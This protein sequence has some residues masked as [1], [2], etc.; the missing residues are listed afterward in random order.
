MSKK[1][2]IALIT[3]AVV[4]LA[5]SILLIILPTNGLASYMF[6]LRGASVSA[7]CFVPTSQS[8]YPNAWQLLKNAGVN[9]IRVSGGMEGDVNHFNM[10][11]YPGEW[12]QNLDDFLTQ[13]ASYGIKVSFTS[14]GNIHG[15][16]FGIVP[17][18]ISDQSDPNAAYTPISQAK[19]MIDQL[20]GNNSLHHNFIMDPRILGW[21]TSN[22]VYIGSQTNSNPNRD[23]P[24]ILKWNLQLLDYIRSKG[25]KAWISSPTVTENVS[26]YDFAKT[27]SLIG[28]HVDFLEAHYYEEPELLTYFKISDGTYNW[29]SFR[30]YYKNLLLNQMV[31]VRGNFSIHGILLGE[32]GMSLGPSSD[33]GF[34]SNFTSQDRI[35]YYQAILVAA[36]DAGLQNVCQH[37]FFEQANT[38]INNYAIVSLSSKNF[39][40]HDA[41]A[42]LME[43]YG[44]VSSSTSKNQIQEFLVWTIIVLPIAAAVSFYVLR[45]KRSDI[46]KLQA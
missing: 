35:N 14:L 27:I 39:Y 15:T 46:G 43:A 2:R 41:G 1:K 9:W 21:V 24:F 19:A 13:A 37:D 17:P 30:D 23:G 7:N 25:G 12:A 16:L 33:F 18:G 4:I 45:K 34:T 32:F 44:G 28:G 42:I 31:N 26:D 10:V 38:N 8:Y 22:E 40:P 36:S 20:A 5:D 11:N 3:I 29:T 6:T